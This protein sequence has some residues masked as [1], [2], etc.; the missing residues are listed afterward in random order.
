MDLYPFAGVLPF[1]M[2]TA[3]AVV[4]AVMSAVVVVM[5]VMAAV[6]VVMVVMAAVCAAAYKLALKV[7]FNSRIRVTGSART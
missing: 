2:M 3:A 7:G 1:R 5:V 4:P 6:V